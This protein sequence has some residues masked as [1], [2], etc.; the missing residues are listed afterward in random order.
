MMGFLMSERMSERENKDGSQVSHLKNQVRDG[1]VT[2]MGEDWGM[3]ESKE[4]E[5]KRPGLDVSQTCR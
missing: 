2:E 3:G 4:A 5:V 1:D